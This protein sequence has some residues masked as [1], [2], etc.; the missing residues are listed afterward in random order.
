MATREQIVKYWNGTRAAEIAYPK[1]RGRWPDADTVD[2]LR[3][4][5]IGFVCDVGCGTGRCADAFNPGAYVGIDINPTAIERAQHE[6]PLHSFRRIDWDDPYPTADTYLFYTCLMHV[7]D[8]DLPLVI[9]RAKPRIVIAE[10]MSRAYRNER[11]FN[12]NRDA[13]DYR[14]VLSE[15]GFGV[16]AFEDHPT[17][18]QVGRRPPLRRRYMVAEFGKEH[19][20]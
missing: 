10:C 19:A 5:C 7:R 6:M 13:D 3:R 20:A 8:E 12:F 18:Y 9:V 17:N 11:A 4:L 14:R 15:C 1:H 2:H 16:V